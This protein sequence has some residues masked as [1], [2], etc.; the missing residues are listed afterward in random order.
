MVTSWLASSLQALGGKKKTRKRL[1]VV[2]CAVL[3]RR[4][5]RPPTPRDARLGKSCSASLMFA[6]TARFAAALL[7]ACAGPTGCTATP[8]GAADAFGPTNSNTSAHT[9]AH[10]STRA[11]GLEEPLLDELANV[12]AGRASQQENTTTLAPAA[13]SAAGNAPKEISDCC[14]GSESADITGGLVVAATLLLAA[15]AIVYIT[16]SGSNTSSASASSSGGSSSSAAAGKPAPHT[17]AAAA[18]NPRAASVTVTIPTGPPQQLTVVLDRI[19]A[20]EGTSYGFGIGCEDL[21]R[22]RYALHDSAAPRAAPTLRPSNT[23]T[24][25]RVHTH[26]HNSH[27]HTHMH[28]RTPRTPRTPLLLVFCRCLTVMLPRHTAGSKWYARLLCAI[29]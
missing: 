20:S 28:T 8:V 21:Y 18:T 22:R 4:P 29:I 1:R 25:T 13:T 24:H 7:L 11:P 12:S 3:A 26:T 6:T 15:L 14:N 17:P 9:S 10:T 2:L 5:H 16:T 23:H 19:D 27:T